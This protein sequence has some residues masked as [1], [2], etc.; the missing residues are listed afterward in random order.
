M[1]VLISVIIPVLLRPLILDM[2]AK[3]FQSMLYLRSRSLPAQAE[4]QRSIRV[5]RIMEDMVRSTPS[6]API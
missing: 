6:S 5:E 2:T 4:L 1:A 3:L